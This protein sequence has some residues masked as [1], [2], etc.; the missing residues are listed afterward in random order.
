MA[1][2][3]LVLVALSFGL[4]Y[5]LGYVA[6]KLN[7]PLYDFAWL[8]YLI[9]FAT[10]LASNLTIIAPVPFAA[11]IMVAAATEWNP[12]LITLFASIGAAIGELTGYYAGYLGKKLAISENVAW[13][14]RIERWI[15]RHGVWSII[16]LSFQPI[17]PFDIGGMIAGAAKMPLHRFLPAVWLGR[18]PK[19]II[20]TYA[21]IGLIH[22][23]PISY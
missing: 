17:I 12:M 1:I 18:F 2:A 8:A 15:Q 21:G 10:S 9:V 11:S 5:L 22:F 3:L 13:Y 14:G 19:Y 6:E 16:F 4:A 20:I 23:L 7:L